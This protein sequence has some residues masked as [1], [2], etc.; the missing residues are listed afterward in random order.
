MVLFINILRKTKLVSNYLNLITTQ[1][2]PY[3]ISSAFVTTLDDFNHGK[4]SE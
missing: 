3:K 1:S 4:E 2:C